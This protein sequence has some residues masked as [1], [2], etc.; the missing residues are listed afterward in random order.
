[1]ATG[2]LF[3]GG[4]LAAANTDLYGPVDGVETIDMLDRSVLSL[5]GGSSAASGVSS[6]NSFPPLRTGRPPRTTRTP[7]ALRPQRTSRC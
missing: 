6:A 2:G 7:W 5:D 3:S 1:M 4:S